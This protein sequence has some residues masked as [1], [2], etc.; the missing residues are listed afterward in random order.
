MWG[1]LLLK[2]CYSAK[3]GYL[4]KNLHLFLALRNSKVQRLG[5]ITSGKWC[6]HKKTCTAVQKLCVCG[7]QGVAGAENWVEAEYSSSPM[8]QTSS[9]S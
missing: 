9:S 4:K 1:C 6:A 3:N 8:P 2:H 5:R 7:D